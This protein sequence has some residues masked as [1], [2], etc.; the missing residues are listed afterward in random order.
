MNTPD[1]EEAKVSFYEEC[2]SFLRSARSDKAVSPL[3][4]A[5]DE[6]D[7]FDPSAGR[8]DDGLISGKFLKLVEWRGVVL[9]LTHPSF[10][11]MIG[12]FESAWS[13]VLLNEA[14]WR[15]TGYASMPTIPPPTSSRIPI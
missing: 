4:A 1:C 7:A 12:M 11:V 9:D 6:H 3:S 10:K 15:A 5:L 13:F 14:A 2:A 8:N